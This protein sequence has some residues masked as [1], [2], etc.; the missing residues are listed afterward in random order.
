[1]EKSPKIIEH[2]KLLKIR[3][4]ERSKSPIKRSVLGQTEEFDSIR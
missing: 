1:M 2:D 3:F 4:D